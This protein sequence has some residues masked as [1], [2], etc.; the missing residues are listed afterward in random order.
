MDFGVT[1]EH[2]HWLPL[3]QFRFHTGLSETHEADR[4]DA[5]TNGDTSFTV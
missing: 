4:S 2:G 1:V 3:S 5:C